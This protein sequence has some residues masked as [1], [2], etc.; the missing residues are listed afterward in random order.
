MKKVRHDFLS[1]AGFALDERWKGRVG[2]LADLT[3]QFLQR[4]AFT[5]QGVGLGD[6]FPRNF[7]REKRES[8]KQDLLE[9]LWI[10]GLGD[11]LGRAERTRVSC[12]GSVVLARWHQDLHGRRMREQVADQ[13]EALVGPVGYG[14]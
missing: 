2:V 13:L 4:G 9:I 12:V 10:A 14:G 11:E 6:P 8:V 3:L 7:C 5:D 1:G